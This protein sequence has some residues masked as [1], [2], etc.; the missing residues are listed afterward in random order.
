MEWKIKAVSKIV[1][2]VGQFEI[3]KKI[4]GEKNLPENVEKFQEL[5]YNNIERWESLKS[6]KRAIQ[7]GDLTPLV[8]F[9][10]YEKI[11]NEIQHKLVGIILPDGK[12]KIELRNKLES[13]EKERWDLIRNRT[14][15]RLEWYNSL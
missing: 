12:E 4:I 10:I 6:Y 5:K 14:R 2:N 9:E 15:E 13:Y 7:T 3:Y 11:K 1:Q 8:S